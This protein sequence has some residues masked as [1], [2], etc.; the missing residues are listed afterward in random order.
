MRDDAMKRTALL[1]LTCLATLGCDL[2]PKPKPAPMLTVTPETITLIQETQEICV[3]VAKTGVERMRNAEDQQKHAREEAMAAANNGGTLTAPDAAS[4][5][6]PSDILEKYLGDE[7]A[8]EIAAVERATGLLRDLL[9]K[10]KDEAPP[11]IAQAVQSLF[12]SEEQACSR[13]R[14][15]RPT[16]L[17]YQESLD[18]AVHDYDSAEAKLQA[19][20]TVTATD[21]QYAANKYNPL[22]DEARA[23]TDHTTGTSAMKPLS[24]EKLRRQRKEWE[25]T[26]Q[27][28]QAQQSQHDAAVVR[29]RQREGKNEPMV[30]KIGL[31]PAEEARRELSPGERGAAVEGWVAR[32]SGE[33]G[34]VR[35]AFAKYM[36]LRKGGSLEQLTP[37]CRELLTAT[38]S[39]VSE[40][41]IFDLPDVAAAKTL[42]KAYTN[43]QECA[44]A[45][46]VGLDAEA[47]YRLAAYEGG[48]SQAAAA[49]QP[50]GVTP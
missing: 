9:P 16:R 3:K 25:P 22:L 38:S 31:A 5:A 47:A 40:P 4:S 44:R 30:G 32:Y 19:V 50:Y 18:Y 15:P 13:A 37:V 8:P 24:P 6:A 27:Y 33:V 39:L 46:V 17:N 29:W 34:P 35:T 1:L 20:Y 48:I 49:L 21:A 12:A 43:L 7:A 41:G 42:K 45:C 36:S 2:A 11:E 23:G 26:Q 28:Q 10:V 14:S